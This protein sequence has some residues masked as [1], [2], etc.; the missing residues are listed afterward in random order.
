MIYWV[1]FELFLIGVV[2]RGFFWF[3]AGLFRGW[4]G[5]VGCVGCFE[6]L[7]GVGTEFLEVSVIV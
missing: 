1:G 6:V 2:G 7:G 4:V 5:G 3:C